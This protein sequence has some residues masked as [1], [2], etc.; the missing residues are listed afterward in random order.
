MRVDIVTP[1]RQLAS[2]EAASV[3]IPGMDGDMTVMD[4]H[5]AVVTTLRPGIVSVA[6]QE[7]SYVVTGGFAE[8]SAEGLSIL[9]EQAMPRAE[10]SSE[11]LNAVLDDAQKAAEITNGDVEAAA[12]QQR[13]NDIQELIRQ[14][15]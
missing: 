13:V 4:N 10:A 2:T 7:M 3:Q 6:G 5:A 1:E 14:L 12:A 11:A 15:T 9:A 8:I